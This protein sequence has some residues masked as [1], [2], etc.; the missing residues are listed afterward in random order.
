VD[1]HA[2]AEYINSNT[3]GKKKTIPTLGVMCQEFGIN[4]ADEIKQ[5]LSISQGTGSLA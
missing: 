2:A 1:G 3:Q 4:G 5:L